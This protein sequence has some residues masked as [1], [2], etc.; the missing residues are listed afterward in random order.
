VKRKGLPTAYVLLPGEGHVFRKAETWK[1]LHE[2][3]LYFF[4]RIFGFEISEQV[5]PVQ[6]ANLPS[7]S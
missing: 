2:G 6:I 1:L 3:E 5:E 7:P 4:S